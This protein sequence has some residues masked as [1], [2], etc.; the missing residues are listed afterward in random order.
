[1]STGICGII[2]TDIKDI[3]YQI[4]LAFYFEKIANELRIGTRMGGNISKFVYDKYTGECG[5]GAVF[6]ELT[7]S[8]VDIHAEELFALDSCLDNGGNLLER[9]TRVKML[10]EKVLN[11][12]HVVQIDF[13]VNYLFGESEHFLC[14]KVSEFCEK[15]M[16]VYKSC[17]VFLPVMKMEIKR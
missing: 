6:F 8:P 16:E 15:I 13:E 10:L 2:R 11:Y 5:K 17:D 4:D 3:S 14:I 7:D 9:L 12:K 1:M